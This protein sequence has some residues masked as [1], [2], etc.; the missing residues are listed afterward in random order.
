MALS[1]FQTPVYF[2]A[3]GATASLVKVLCVRN[4]LPTIMWLSPSQTQTRSFIH[5]CLPTAWQVR[6]PVRA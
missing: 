1:S 3:R 4:A 6:I 2:T 5:S